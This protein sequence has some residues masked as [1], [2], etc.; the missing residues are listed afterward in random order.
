LLDSLL[1]EILFFG[2]MSTKSRSF[3]PRR[4]IKSES[5][6]SRSRSASGSPS[7]LR[8][9][10]RTPRS[11][12]SPRSRSP[13]P[14]SRSYEIKKVEGD[15][16]AP[17]PNNCL[18]VF[19]LSY[20]T[21]EEELEHKFSKYGPLE[22]ANL[23]LDGPS[24]KSRGFGF[25]YFQHVEDATKARDAMNGKELDGFKVRV[26]YSITRDAHQRTPGV[27][28]HHG[29]AHKP[30][31]KKLRAGEDRGRG[32]R[33]GGY[34][35]S[36]SRYREERGGRDRDYRRERAPYPD[37]DRDYYREDRHYRDDRY[38]DRRGDD[39][40]YEDRDRYYRE[41]DY[42]RSRYYERERRYERSPPPYARYEERER[43][44]PAVKSRSRRS[45]SPG[46]S[47]RY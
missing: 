14:R 42:E 45:P 5:G 36:S 22:K 38:D 16:E 11:R 40:Y 47:R 23:V 17:E 29:K 2:K 27:Y 13:R 44:P 15:R 20:K 34:Q 8:T 37:Y 6:R 24:R 1:Q 9:R 43:Y 26:D 10:S 3:S 4:R 18:G 19:G 46:P 12:G 32:D 33:R 30:G 41:R 25:V 21:T 35:P 39:R 7:P 31:E 28:Y